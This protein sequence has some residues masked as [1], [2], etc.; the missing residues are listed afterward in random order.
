MRAAVDDGLHVTLMIWIRPGTPKW[1]FDLG[2]PKVYTDRKVDSLGR[3]MSKEDNL[4]PYYLHPEYKKHFFAL[5]DA[6][7]TYVN[8]LPDDLKERVVFVQSSEGFHRRR[9][10]LQGHSAQYSLPHSGGCVERLSQGNL[11]P[12]SESVP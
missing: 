6:F 10:A 7:G 2:V 11:A 9:T 1:L 5:I 4:H 12:L 8:G 3:T